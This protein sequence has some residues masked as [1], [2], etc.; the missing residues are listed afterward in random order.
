MRKLKTLA[1]FMITLIIT[2]PIYTSI[3][4]ADFYV[5]SITG[6]DGAYAASTATGYRRVDD[7]TIAKII[8]DIN[9]VRY[10]KDPNNKLPCSEINGS[11]ECTFQK[12]TT[13]YKSSQSYMFYQ[14]PQNTGNI[15]SKSISVDSGSPTFSNMEVLMN[16]GNVTFKFKVSDPLQ[17]SSETTPIGSGIKSIEFYVDGSSKGTY[18]YS[19]AVGTREIEGTY[20]FQGLADGLRT[21]H[22]ESTDFVGNR[23]VSEPIEY[24]VDTTAPEISLTNVKK[25]NYDTG[26]YE[27]IAYISDKQIDGVKIYL[28]ISDSSDS[29]TVTGD[30]SELG[31]GN[32]YYKSSYANMGFTCT[33]T[34]SLFNCSSSP[35]SLF[36]STSTSIIKITAKDK[37]GNEKTQEIPV[38]LNLDTTVPKIEGI[39]TNFCDDYGICYLNGFN[40]SVVVGLTETESGF[41]NR[42]V[43]VSS[44][45]ITSI[46][47]ATQVD[48]CQEGSPWICYKDIGPISFT[49]GSKQKISVVYPTMDDVGNYADP[50][51][52]EFIVDTTA[53]TL[54][55]GPKFTRGDGKPFIAGNDVMSIKIT[56]FENTSG[57]KTVTADLSKVVTGASW[58]DTTCSANSK[59]GAGYFDCEWITDPV[60]MGPLSG[61]TVTFN[62]SD[63]AGNT[64]SFKGTTPDILK[65]DVS[66]T[67]F[68]SGAVK[69]LD[70][71]EVDRVTSKY[72]PGKLTVWAEIGLTSN[73]PLKHLYT[74]IEDC[75]GIDEQ[76][77][78]FLKNAKVYPITPSDTELPTSN[79]IIL[80]E[81][82]N[83]EIPDTISQFR[84]KCTLL[85]SSSSGKTLYEAEKVQVEIAIPIRNIGSDL[86]EGYATRID[87][88]KTKLKDKAWIGSLQSFM[89][90]GQKVCTVI[91]IL[92]KLYNLY[93]LLTGP[94]IFTFDAKGPFHGVATALSTTNNLGKIT[95]S[96]IIPTV[97]FWTCGFFE[98][99]LMDKLIS[100]FGGGDN[101]AIKLIRWY[102]L[103]L[104]SGGIS[105]IAG[106]IKNNAKPAK[107]TTNDPSTERQ[108]ASTD[109]NANSEFVEGASTLDASK[110]SIFVAALTLCIPGIIYNLEKAR[111]IDCR[112]VNCAQNN[113]IN[114]GIDP[115]VCEDMRANA[116][117]NFVY[118]QV[119]HLIPF[120]GLL[121][122]FSEFLTL[123]NTNPVL[124]VAMVFGLLCVINSM[125]N[126][127]FLPS[128]GTV[129]NIADNI[130]KIIDFLTGTFA[131]FKSFGEEGTT[132]YC[133][134][135][136]V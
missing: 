100:K 68:W 115:Y 20:V 44:N 112:Y 81:L 52:Q 16:G 13:L 71:T 6:S 8:S 45:S 53:P 61:Q 91:G 96:T 67:L 3:V 118:G 17:N 105:K 55:K 38:L 90:I 127:P 121:A 75:E 30:L 36:V 59:K 113:V 72:L 84:Y 49:E 95:S 12:Q 34:D 99:T 85:I 126:T 132:D 79:A 110:N 41:S 50:V 77:Q 18:T 128:F 69:S 120:S 124:A 32:K 42:L 54:I 98:C 29:L 57:L 35:I 76:S 107:G 119:F 125:P 106:E 74:G 40:N 2:L 56:V 111:Q 11:Y 130:K 70:P 21:F 94:P 123:F 80:L 47:S 23:G 122:K 82:E 63:Y 102:I 131:T 39:L 133:Q 22:I 19:Y 92:I 1:L 48:Y 88:L 51:D 28:S 33:K 25:Y 37:D 114:N 83:G 65:K 89:D 9:D 116:Y 4:Y 26:T 136:G 5:A 43:F 108:T 117:C 129:C 15:I 73:T 109:S 31:A 104:S 7:L 46:S 103:S 93:Q 60:V 58:V 24:T 87:E 97:Y 78:S 134:K 135:I 66:N 64:L 86:P 14:Y 10:S 27:D 101:V 62:V